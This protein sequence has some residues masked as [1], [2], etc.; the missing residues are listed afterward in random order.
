MEPV[1]LLGIVAFVVTQTYFILRTMN[2]AKAKADE[3]TAAQAAAMAAAQESNT[4]QQNAVTAQF[5]RLSNDAVRLQTRIDTLELQA[6]AANVDRVKVAAELIEAKNRA[7]ERLNELRMA[8][9]NIARLMMEVKT[10]TEKVATLETERV[11]REAELVRERQQVQTTSHALATANDKIAGLQQ[12]VS[13]LEAENATLMM[14]FQK[15]NVIA[16]SPD[17]NQP[18][19]LPDPPPVAMHS[20]S[21]EITTAISTT[22]TDTSKAA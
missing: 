11:V 14:M 13:A 21:M 7:D 6:D 20:S 18:P 22:K 16:V 15:L 8:Q 5:T 3:A 17:G 12:R 10:L 9:E 4:K 2:N 19:D 1:T